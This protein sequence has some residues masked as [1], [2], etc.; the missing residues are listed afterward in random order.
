[1]MPAEVV[2]SSSVEKGPPQYST[3]FTI[4]TRAVDSGVG[5]GLQLNGRYFITFPGII[6]IVQVIIAIVCM[7]C[8]SPPVTWFA[9]L[10]TFVVAESFAITLLLIFSYSVT[11]S[12]VVL[13]NVHWTFIE[14]VYTVITALGYFITSIIHL[15]LTAQDSDGYHTSYK[16]SITYYGFYGAYIAAGVFGLLNSFVYTAGSYF[17]FM[18]WRESRQNG[19][20]SPVTR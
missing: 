4:R 3:A 15:A 18:E 2:H 13:P 14:L 9:R 1:M 19:A 12:A 11:L 5:E 17:L 7:S 16:F 10:F 20:V 6:K 8:I